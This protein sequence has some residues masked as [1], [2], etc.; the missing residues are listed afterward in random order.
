MP[1]PGD[2]VLHDDIGALILVL[3]WKN[4]TESIR[5]VANEAEAYAIYQDVR[6]YDKRLVSAYTATR[7]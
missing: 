5:N 1:N 4:G 6:K 3:V 7:N 2:T